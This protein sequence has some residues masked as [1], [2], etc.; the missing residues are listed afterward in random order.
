M[1]L[2]ELHSDDRGKIFILNEDLGHPELTIFTTKKGFARG[3]CIHHQNKE[4]VCVISGKIK[5]VFST[6]TLYLTTGESFTIPKSTPHY[7]LSVTDS[8]VAE[9]GATA[10]EKI[11]KHLEFRKIV[12][13]INKVGII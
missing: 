4:N 7:F 6:T 5:Y 1:K 12:E 3:G 13:N 8:V 9:W 11:E 10:E 2:T